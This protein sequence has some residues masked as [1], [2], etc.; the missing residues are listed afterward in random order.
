MQNLKNAW[1]YIKQHVSRAL[2]I[3]ADK[4]KSADPEFQ[5]DKLVY[6]VRQ[7]FGL[8]EKEEKVKNKSTVIYLAGET[9]E[10][11]VGNVFVK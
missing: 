11:A 4:A 1:N 9:E 10:K 6:D 8:T 3:A 2:E 5:R 7:S